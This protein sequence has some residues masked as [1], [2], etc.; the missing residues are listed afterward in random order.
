VSRQTLLL[1]R[2]WT[3]AGGTAVLQSA[4]PA[5]GGVEARGICIAALGA[6][7]L[8]ILPITPPSTCHPSRSRS[9]T[10]GMCQSRSPE[11]TLQCN[12][13]TEQ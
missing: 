4:A 2:P 1:L 3:M 6:T 11:R 5:L 12:V 13:R 8:I 9:C 10:Q 7:F